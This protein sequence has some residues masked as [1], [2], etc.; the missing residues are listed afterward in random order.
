MRN[1]STWRSLCAGTAAAAATLIVAGGALAQDRPARIGAEPNLNGIWQA[2]NGAY[3]NLEAHPAEQLED[4]WQLGAIGAIPAGLG[5]VEGDEIPYLPA[6]LAQRDANAAAWPIEDPEAKCYLPGIPRATYMSYPFQIIQAGDGTDLLFVY[7]YAT[8][9][10]VIHTEVHNEPPIDTWMGLSN[11]TWEGDTLVVE[12]TGF[13]G[14]SWLDRAGNYAG[15][16]AKITERF[17]PGDDGH[18]QYE[19]T[20]ENPAVFSRPW[21][22]SMPLYRRVEPNAQVL[23]FKCVPFSEMMLYGDLK[24]DDVE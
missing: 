9:N 12:T 21:T 14:M 15:A 3:W 18:M 5:V 8:A 19:A 17:T 13:N 10:R 22:I 7:E 4:F 11:G 16:G 2:M 24:P 6:A 20:I 23:E 1:G